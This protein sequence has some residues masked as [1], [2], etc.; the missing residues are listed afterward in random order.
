M[1]VDFLRPRSEVF[2]IFEKGGSQ[3]GC[4]RAYKAT[5]VIRG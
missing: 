4:E 1:N 2:F 5:K 3:Y